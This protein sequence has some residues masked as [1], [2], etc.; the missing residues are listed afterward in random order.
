[1]G[2]TGMLRNLG[3]LLRRQD[4][5]SSGREGGLLKRVPGTADGGIR[6]EM[7]QPFRTLGQLF[8]GVEGW[9]TLR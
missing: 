2:S 9:S 8:S 7:G 5:S 4:R 6:L 3:S 1:M